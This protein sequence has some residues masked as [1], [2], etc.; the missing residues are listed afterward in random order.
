MPHRIFVPPPQALDRNLALEVVRVTEASALAAALWMGRGDERAADKAASAAMQEALNSLAMEGLIVNGGA[1]EDDS[2]L[3]TGE[4]V[5]SGKGPRVDIALT[6]LEGVTICA[7]ASHNALSVVAATDS[8]SFLHVPHNVYMEKIAVG[9]RLPQGV[10]DLDREPAENLARV[11]AAK[12]VAVTDLTVCMLDRPRHAELLGRIYDAGAR[13]VLIDD[14]DV[15]GAIATGLPET[16]I[17]LYMGSGGAAEGV[18]AA[19]GLKCLGGQMQ[20]R[21]MLRSEEERARARNA[22]ID[23]LSAKW[24]VDQMVRGDVMFAATGITDG[25]LLKGVRFHKGGAV[26]HSMVMRS[27]TGTIRMLT[28]RHDFEKHAKLHD[29]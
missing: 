13:V 3:H 6:A 16:G 29:R 9:G 12:G 17:D 2:P 15:S 8:G 5:G 25:H 18:L 21:L 22:G 19:A 28:A 7:K 24:N 1:D 10:I 20:C 27:M 11:A 14:G 4:K 23:D 26:S